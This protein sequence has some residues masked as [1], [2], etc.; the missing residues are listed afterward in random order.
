VRLSVAPGSP[1]PRLVLRRGKRKQERGVRPRRVRAFSTV[2]GHRRASFSGEYPSPYPEAGGL[3]EGPPLP[4]GPEPA[5]YFRPGYF[6][7]QERHLLN[8]EVIPAFPELA[9]FGCQRTFPFSQAC[10]PASFQPAG[11]PG[12]IP[13]LPG[14]RQARAS[15]LTLRLKAK[16]ETNLLPK[17]LS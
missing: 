1:A 8:L 13:S 17:S 3:P 6:E 9:L 16:G 10:S 11:L 4:P 5:A 7:A 15:P 14:A 12:G 2:W